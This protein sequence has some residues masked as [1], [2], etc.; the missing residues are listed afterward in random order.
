[1]LKEVQSRNIVEDQEK[2]ARVFRHKIL[3]N[4]LELE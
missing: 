4:M 3:D 2:T 1:M